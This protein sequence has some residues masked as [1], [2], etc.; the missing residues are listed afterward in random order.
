M[1]SFYVL[2]NIQ[3]V[4]SWLFIF[5]LLWNEAAFVS[6]TVFISTV[7]LKQLI[8][9][10]KYLMFSSQELSDCWQK[11]LCEGIWGLIFFFRQRWIMLFDVHLWHKQLLTLRYNYSAWHRESSLFESFCHREFTGKVEV[12][13]VFILWDDRNLVLSDWGL[14]VTHASCEINLSLAETTY[15]FWFQITGNQPTHTTVACQDGAQLS[16]FPNSWARCV[17]VM[18]FS[19]FRSLVSPHS[20]CQHI[21]YKW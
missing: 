7:E 3:V 13:V 9:Y 21:C 5:L 15:R 10:L 20:C 12:G 6:C 18:T 2:A 19:Q 16:D 4:L 17:S 14:P 8:K 11:A 1:I